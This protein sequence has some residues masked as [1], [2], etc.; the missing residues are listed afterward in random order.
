MPSIEALQPK[1]FTPP[2]GAYSQGIKVPLPGAEIVFITGQVAIDSERKPIAPNDIKKQTEAVFEKIKTVLAE[3]HF[4]LQDVVKV[5]IFVTNMNDKKKVSEVRNRYL[6]DCKPVSTLV[7][8]NKLVI[9]G[10][11]VEIDAIAI[12][13][14][15]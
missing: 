10:C 9:D 13:L 6:T 3:A 11:D 12:K 15:G 14:T 5:Q 1:N 7:E 4:S 2:Y 8:V